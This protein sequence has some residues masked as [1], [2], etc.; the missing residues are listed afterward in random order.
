MAL[1][2]ALMTALLDDDLSGYELA[3]NFDTSVGFVWHASHQQIYR[4]L[5]K[6]AASGEVSAHKVAQEG[7]PD[8][9]VYRLTERGADSLAQWVYDDSRVQSTKDDLLVKLYNLDPSNAS[10]LIN[11]LR[12][13]RLHYEQRLQL[14][15]KIRQRRFTDPAR[16]PLR[17]QGIY[18]VWM[19]GKAVALQQIEWCDSSIAWIERA[20]QH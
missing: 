1:C 20:T 14:L 13:R 8:K 19:G 6:L 11:E 16:L 7:R 18:L 10:H 9:V 2:H 15:E 12:G 3:R 4:E 5:K 17:Q